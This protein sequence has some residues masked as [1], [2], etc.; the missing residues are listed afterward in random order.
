MMT[1]SLDGSL[2]AWNLETG[3]Q[4]GNDWRDEESGVYAAALSPDGKKIVSGGQGCVVKL[5]DIDTAKAIAKWT[6]HGSG[7]TSVCWNRDGGRILSGSYD[8]TAI[9]AETT[10]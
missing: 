4:I 1:C 7:I 8:G 5:W 2:R 9:T 10:F 6:G 3:G